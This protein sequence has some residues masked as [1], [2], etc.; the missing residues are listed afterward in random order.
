MKKIPIGAV[1]GGIGGGVGGVVGTLIYNRERDGHLKTLDQQIDKNNQ[2]LTK[3][4]KTVDSWANRAE[5]TETNN[6]LV[7]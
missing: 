3:V 1:A 5:Q 7:R 2:L 6:D 4:E